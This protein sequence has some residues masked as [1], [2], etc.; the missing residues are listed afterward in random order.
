TFEEHIEHLK[1]IFSLIKNANLRINSEKYHFCTNKIQ[2]LRYIVGINRIK[3]DPQKV[4]KFEKLPPPKTI[5]QLRAFIG[6]ASY[7]R[8]F[9]ENFTKKAAP[10]NKLLQKDVEFIWTEE[11]N[12]IFNYLKQYL[13]TAPILQYS[14]Y[15][16][17][18]IIFTDASYQG[19]EAILSQ[20]KDRKEH[21]I[22]YASRTLTPAKKNYST[23]KLECLAVIQA[24]KYF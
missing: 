19:L 7:Y 14:D 13:I 10:L 23:V 16:E 2:F 1:S 12:K 17:P 21:I 11:H 3:P 8:R 4:E 9:I 20:V 5:T 15:N 6:L 22:A 18:F 24:I